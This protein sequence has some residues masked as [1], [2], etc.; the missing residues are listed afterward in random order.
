MRTL[1]LLAIMIVTFGLNY[2]A[3]AEILGG[4][5]SSAPQSQGLSNKVVQHTPDKN[6]SREAIC[7]PL[8]PKLTV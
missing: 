8:R 3:E 2:L 4:P 7:S 5:C 6:G 1:F